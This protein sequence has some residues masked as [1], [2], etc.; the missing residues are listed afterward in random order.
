[1]IPYV[2]DMDLYATLINGRRYDI[3]DINMLIHE[4]TDSA[5]DWKI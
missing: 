3:G 4:F 2:R 1:M 5:K